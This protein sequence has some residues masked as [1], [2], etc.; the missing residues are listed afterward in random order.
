MKN[1]LIFLYISIQLISI[2]RSIPKDI[3]SDILSCI[4]PTVDPCNDF[5][6]YACGNWIKVKFIGE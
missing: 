1:P 3:A 4:D 6:D 2:V 5:Y